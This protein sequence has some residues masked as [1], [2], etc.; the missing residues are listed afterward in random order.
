MGHTLRVFQ[1]DAFTSE[2]FTGNPAGVVLDAQGLSPARMQAIARELGQGDTAFVLP[3]A[4]DTHDVLMR[5]FTP[6]VEA[7]FVGHA[8]L[9]AHAVLAALG[10]PERPRQMQ[11]TGLVTV[12]RHARPDGP[13]FAFCQPPPPLHDGAAPAWLDDALGA[14]GLA[15]DELDPRLPP[16]V[17]GAASTRALIALRDP[18]RLPSLQPDLARL[19]ALST[20]GAPPGFFAYVVSGAGPSLHTAARMYCPALGIPED[21]VSGNAHAMLAHRLC[22]AGLV[23]GSVPLARFSGEQGRPMGR[24]GQVDVEVEN[25]GG[26]PQRIR[27]AGA[28]TIVW[29]ARLTLSG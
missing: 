7:G 18:Q 12:E 11:R 14:L 16:L 28:A 22:V 8:T 19:A 3:P 26:R 23:D 10:L 24:P 15:H 6:R 9:A 21:P 29:E 5:F 27:I 4:D 20:A 17:A 1:V 13:R 25:A 2:P